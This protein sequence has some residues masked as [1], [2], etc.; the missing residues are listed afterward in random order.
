MSKLLASL[1]RNYFP[2]RPSGAPLHTLSKLYDVPVGFVTP[3]ILRLNIAYFAVAE[4]WLLLDIGWFVLF[5]LS[6]FPRLLQTRR[7][8]C[9]IHS[10]L[11]SKNL[12]ITSKVLTLGNR[13]HQLRKTFGKFFRSYSELLSKFSDISFQ[14][15]VFKGISHP[16]FY[17]D[18]VYKLRRVKDTPNF[19]SSGS[20]IVNTP[21]TMTVWPIDH[22]ED[23]RS[24]ALP[25]YSLVQT[26]SKALHS[27]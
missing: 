8:G 26:F 16:V 27:D 13:Y 23:Y 17:G 5:F 4:G 22:R 1:M 21:S 9:T 11:N 24:C 20:I 25:L 2:K 10:C 15:Y 19:I 6:T 14:E 7:P 18:I 12:Q 3:P